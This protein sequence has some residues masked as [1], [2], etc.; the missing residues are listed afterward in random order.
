MGGPHT[1][2]VNKQNTLASKRE[3]AALHWA[4]FMP[5]ARVRGGLRNTAAAACVTARASDEGVDRLARR[6]LLQPTGRCIVVTGKFRR[7]AIVC[8]CVWLSWS[9]K[10]VLL[11]CESDFLGWRQNGLG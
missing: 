4:R 2:T 1:A 3:F 5:R 11:L 9:L 6:P 10:I 7:V 8:V